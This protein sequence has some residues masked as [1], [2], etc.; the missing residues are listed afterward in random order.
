MYKIII[1]SILFFSFTPFLYARDNI[2]INNAWVREVPPGSSVSAVYMQIQNSG[3]DDS[4]IDISSGISESA[5][6]HT[7]KV[8]KDGVATMEMT[9]I[10]EIPSNK[11]IELE[12]GGMHLML[13]GLKETL[14]GKKSVSLK[15]VFDK[16]GEIKIEV[17]VKK[18]GM[19]THKHKH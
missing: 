13:I 5:E 2:V 3:E 19:E 17:P 4:L 15:L 1:V 14:V 16:A 9:T 18:S 11:S 12:P 7:S 8:D 6:L 10:L